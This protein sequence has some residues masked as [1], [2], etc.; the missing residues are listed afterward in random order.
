M[1]RFV[2]ISPLAPSFDRL[3]TSG[4][5]QKLLYPSEN[6]SVHQ[7]IASPGGTSF[8]CGDWFGEPKYFFPR[9][10]FFLMRRLVRRTRVFLPS[11]ELLSH[12]RA[13]FGEPEYFSPWRNHF[14]LKRLVRRNLE[15]ILFRSE[16]S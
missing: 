9:T 2:A 14:L 11:E 7:L 1:P 10:N 13:W 6:D 16:N 4:P 12:A 3:V 15:K 5:S 8:S